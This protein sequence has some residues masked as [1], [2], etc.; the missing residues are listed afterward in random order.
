VLRAVKPWEEEAGMTHREASE[1]VDYSDS[2]VSK[3]VSE[4]RNGE[5]ESV[6]PHGGESA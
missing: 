4:W 5:W 3:R 1:L 2:W 6:T